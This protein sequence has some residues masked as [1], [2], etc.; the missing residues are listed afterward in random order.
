MAGPV[1]DT[2]C[3]LTIGELAADADAVWDRARD[4][5]VEGAVVIGIDAATSKD[6]VEF[7]ANRDHLWGTVGV[8]PNETAKATESDWETIQQLATCDKI[9]ALGETGLD[10]YWDDAPLAT[11]IASLRRHATFAIEIDLPIVLHLRDAFQPAIETL[12]PFAARGLRAVVHCF[13]GTEHDLRPFLDW[14]WMISYSGILT[15]SGATALR[16][17]AAATPLEQCLIE[18]DAPWLAPAPHKSQDRNEPAFV[19]HTARRLAK[20]KQL[21]FDELAAATTA[22]ARRFF[23]LG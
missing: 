4:S 7:V 3:H 9:V 11:Q 2:H 8:H 12:E 5:G 18:T 16:A 15:Y 13:T 23:R 14:G 22:N 21:P 17:A 1:F 10:R 20:V 19:V 6:V